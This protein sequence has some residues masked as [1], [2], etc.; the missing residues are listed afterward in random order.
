MGMVPTCVCVVRLKPF[1]RYTVEAL[2]LDGRVLIV[3]LI[4][5]DSTISFPEV[6]LALAS[7]ERM[8]KN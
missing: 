8:S 2:P 7:L 4:V 3:L 6:T 5:H 1:E